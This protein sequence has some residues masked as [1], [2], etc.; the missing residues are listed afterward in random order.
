MHTYVSDYV[1][2][3]FYVIYLCPYRKMCTIFS[4]DLHKN[5]LE[6]VPYWYVA[7]YLLLCFPADFSV[8]L[9]SLL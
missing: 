9:S 7:L 8:A 3:L 2:P 4:Y 1:H 5:N 6:K